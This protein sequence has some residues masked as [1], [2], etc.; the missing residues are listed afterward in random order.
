MRPAQV[1]AKS[2]LTIPTILAVVILVASFVVYVIHVSAS[3]ALPFADGF[4]SGDFSHWTSMTVTGDGSAAVQ[5]QT[6]WGGLYAARLS[7]TSSS[8][9]RAYLRKVIADADV[10][11]DGM[12]N[13]QAEGAS[14]GNVPIFRFFDSA[15]TRLISLYRQNGTGGLWVS[16]SGV[17]YSTGQVIALN[18]W[19]RLEVRSVVVSDGASTVQVWLNGVKV[20]E[21]FAASLGTQLVTSVQLGNETGGQTG[22]VI[23]DN[24]LI[25]GPSPTS[26]PTG[27]GTPS[28]TATP[29]PTPTATEPATPTATPTATSTPTATETPTLTPTETPTPTA[30]PSQTATASPTQ[31]PPPT[32]SATQTPTPTAT[33]TPTHTPTPTETPTPTATPSQTAT[34]SPTQTPSPT[35]SPTETPLPTATPTPTITLPALPTPTPTFTSTPTPTETPTPTQTPTPTSTNTPTPTATATPTPTTTPTPTPTPSQTPS[36]TP[37][38][39]PTTTATATPT[40]TATVT[41]TPTETRTPTATPSLTPTATPT[42]TP[43]PTATSTQ[44]ATPT[45]TETPTSTPTATLTPT[46]TPTPTATPTPTTT[47]TPTATPS[48]TPT[49]TAQAADIGYRDFTYRDF[50]SVQTP[51]EDKPQS[52]LWFQDGTW[53]GLLYSTSSHATAI[54]SLDV[55]RQIWMDTGMTVDSRPTARGD[56][57]WDSQTGKRYVVSGTTVVSEFGTPPSPSDVA[58]GSA[59]LSRFSYNPSA[60]NYTLDAGFPATVHSGSTE[61]ITLARDSTGLLWVTYTLVNPDNTSAVYVN[62]SVGN[63]T[64]WGSPFVLPTTAAGVHYDDISAIVAFQGTKIGVMWSNQLNRKFYL[65]VHGDG[66]PDNSW[67]TVVAYG[68]SVGGCSTGCANDHVNLKQ[69]SSDGSGRIFAAIKTANRNT[70]QPFVVLIVRDNHAK[71]SAYPFGAV[72]DLHTRP[73]VMIDEEHRELFMFAVSPEVGGT[74]Y[75]KKSPIDNISFETGLGTPFMQSSTDTD[76]SN[77]TSTKQNLNTATGLVVL[78]SANANAYYWHNYLSL[79][80]EPAPPPAAPSNLTLTSPVLNP[81]TTLQLAWTDNSTNETGFAIERRMGTG[82]YSEIATVGASVTSYTDTGL[83]AGTPYSYRV[84]A[85]NAVGYSRYSDEVSDTTAQTGAVRTFAP[86]ADA[87]VDSSVPNTN[88]GTKKELF[89]DAS[90]VQQAYLKFQ[91]AGLTGNTVTSAKLRLYVTTNGSV[92][93]GSAAK[94]SNTSWGETTVTYNTRPAIDGPVLST[95]EVVNTNTWYA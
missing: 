42:Q 24:I 60:R 20:Y 45:P 7:T 58:A 46:P 38:P 83:T 17:R 44:T 35:A 21:T 43:T 22:T 4:E 31:T 33:A 86:V 63:D 87:Y 28:P 94:V 6:V 74:I 88:N 2:L 27:T 67:Q 25:T 16:H 69:L 37:T 59:E 26:T 1:V 30:T 49:A 12:F 77:P 81:D 41:P 15:G 53:W 56:A 51:T 8:T 52:K 71:W 36:P 47:P 78:A 73:M 48:Q 39:T 90:P 61:S 72:E 14:G 23:A 57:L 11:A 68:G 85:W 66:S 84:R 34:A 10:H 92:K 19:N 89:V 76:I 32:A 40:P 80:G 65:A 79:A 62:H 50:N 54:F 64:T 29:T 5:Q 13:V 91:L 3:P 9:S 82:T 18:T 75:Y 55:S 70:G 93:G 95:L